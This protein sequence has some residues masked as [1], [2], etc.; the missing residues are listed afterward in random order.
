MFTFLLSYCNTAKT[1]Y[2]NSLQCCGPKL[3]NRFVASLH[4][5]ALSGP[6]L[7]THFQYTRLHKV[8]TFL[9]Q[10]AHKLNHTATSTTLYLN[11]Y[12]F[13]NLSICIC[14]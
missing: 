14:I 7:Q 9:K 10:V 2:V 5:E 3:L 8:H 4:N 1:A 13:S 6:L 11:H 12:F